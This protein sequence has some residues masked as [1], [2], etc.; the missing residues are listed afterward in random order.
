M[1]PAQRS[2]LRQATI[3]RAAAG[4]LA[5]ITGLLIVSLVLLGKA[6]DRQQ[7]A[8][9]RQVEFKA[10]SLEL[11]AASDFLT[12]EARA[13]A[14]TADREHLD[15]YWREIDATKT[16]DK[17]VAR[18]QQLGAEKAELDLVAEAKANS[19]ALVQTETRSQRLV[20]EA[21][22]TA[23]ADMPSAIADYA[24]SAADRALSPANKLTVARQI[25]FDAQYDADK[26]VIS[27]PL[28]KFQNSLNQR[29][30]K[31]VND[32]QNRI[33]TLVGLLL[34]LAILLPAAMGA[35]L[36]LLQ[37]KV[38]RVVV[39]YTRALSLRD[40][41]DLRFRIEPTGT[42]ELRELG[43]AFNEELNR[44]LELVRTMSSS[45]QTVA[46]AAN[47]LA[48]TS[49]RVAVSAEQASDGTVTVSAAA[50]QV[51]TNVQ[52]VAA[53]AEEMGASIREIAQNAQEAARV[54]GD[55]VAIAESTNDTVT[56]LGQSSTEIGNVINVIT[57][58]AEQTNLLALNATIEAARAGEAG[59]GFAVV[60]SEVKDLA[61]E[62]AKATEEISSRIQAIQSDTGAAVEA[63]RRISD[64]IGKINDYQTAIA[65]A[66][67]EQTA[68]TNEMSRSVTEAATGSEHI[69]LNI[70]MVTQA[71]QAAAAGITEAKRAATELAEMGAQLETL[72]GHYR[73]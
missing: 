17:V 60:A 8:Q 32:S 50:N 38:G 66:V 53:G 72:V 31:E 59:K 12:N 51:S 63:I 40:Q 33:G 5:A 11:Q 47:E 29:A 27:A 9:E 13:Y 73:Y 19:D 14:V 25:M 7:A 67:E 68:T 61:Q 36:F 45:A 58:V 6:V 57:S 41:N 4:T 1:S 56:K 49:Q 34:G 37:S 52:T 46:S 10:L 42:R 26:A 3:N 23:P 22:G 44:S 64:V 48:R 62:T 70:S 30:A 2:G 69:A 28:A 43:G 54:G 39:Q 55:A 15:A 16:R 20:L 21:S 35:V 65:G 71:T 18:L 24:L